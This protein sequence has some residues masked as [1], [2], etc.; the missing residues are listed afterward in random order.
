MLPCLFTPLS[1][2]DTSWDRP[3]GFFILIVTVPAFALRL[4]VSN[5]SALASALMLRVCPPPEGAAGADVAEDL[6]VELELLF[7]DPQPEATSA[8]ITRR[9]RSGFM[10]AH[11][12]QI[13]SRGTQEA[14]FAHASGFRPGPRRPSGPRRGPRR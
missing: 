9:E 2:M 12:N 11:T 3:P 5:L 13:S 6:V 14:L 8:A 4:V 7:E 10:A 1:L